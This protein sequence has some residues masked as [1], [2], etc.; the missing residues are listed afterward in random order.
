MTEESRN[1]SGKLMLLHWII[2]LVSWVVGLLLLLLANSLSEGNIIGA[3]I[4]TQLAAIIIISVPIRFISQF[5]LRNRY[6]IESMVRLRRTISKQIAKSI[7]SELNSVVSSGIVNV[8]ESIDSKK[9]R[10]F[11]KSAH[12]TR[13]R[14]LK[15]WIPYLNQGISSKDFIEA[16]NIRNCTFEIILL[17]PESKEAI[18]KRCCSLNYE[19]SNFEHHIAENIDFLKIVYREIS[20]KSGLTLR[21]HNSFI[22]ASLIGN[23]D[24]YIKGSYHHGTASTDS[25]QLIVRKSLGDQ[26]DGL[27]EIFDRHFD[28]QWENSKIAPLISEPNN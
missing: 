3:V 5:F 4:L 2:I 7:P 17:A 12:N 11:I 20:N 24:T 18:E 21:L 27:F 14:I 13:I 15:I 28:W 8:W 9:L 10:D 6:E 19:V 1:S 16:I 26:M 23:D 25:I 22:S